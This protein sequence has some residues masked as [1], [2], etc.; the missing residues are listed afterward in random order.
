MGRNRKG[1]T[2]VVASIILCVVVL[3]AGTSVW[4]FTYSISSELQQ[5]YQERIQDQ[6]DK[7][8]ERFTI[9]HIAYDGANTLSV[10]VYNYVFRMF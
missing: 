3:I 1:L 8:S 6:I 10:W 4:A 2:S 7:I 9:E 5:G